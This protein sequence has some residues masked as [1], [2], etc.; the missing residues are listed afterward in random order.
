MKKMRKGQQGCSI[1][2][3]KAYS[4]PNASGNTGFEQDLFGLGLSVLEMSTQ[5]R[6]VVLA[7]AR[8]KENPRSNDPGFQKLRLAIRS[9]LP[10]R[11]NPTQTMALN[12]VSAALDHDAPFTDRYGAPA[13]GQAGEHLLDRVDPA[14]HS[15]ISSTVTG[16]PLPAR[17]GPAAAQGAQAVGVQ[18]VGV[19]AQRAQA[20]GAQA[21]GVQAQ[22]AL[23]GAVEAEVLKRAVDQ[24]VEKIVEDLANQ[25]ESFK[26]PNSTV[27]QQ[28]AN[29]LEMDRQLKAWQTSPE[30]Q[31]QIES[32]LQGL[33]PRTTAF[34]EEL[35]AVLI[36]QANLLHLGLY[37]AACKVGGDNTRFERKLPW[38]GFEKIRLLTT[39]ELLKRV[40]LDQA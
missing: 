7:V 26:F 22:G 9:A 4:H 40:G 1:V 25:N 34:K 13:Q 21:V 38:A 35:E 3:T 32:R 18:A 15:N 28:T 12:W 24:M 37:V 17:P 6:N 29:L 10:R 27:R 23:N 19:Q 8:Y 16:I 2:S 5:N 11:L 31:K 36:D 14:K 39:E 20:I 33:D 30:G